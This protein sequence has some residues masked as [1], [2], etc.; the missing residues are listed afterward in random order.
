MFTLHYHPL[1]S[2]CHK[3]L[4]ALYERAVP[5]TGLVVD[6]QDAQSAAE[7]QKLWPVG[8]IPVLRDERNGRAVPETSIIIEYLDRAHPGA[9][10]LLPDDPDSQ[11][12]ARLWDR[13]FDLYVHTPMQKFVFDRLR[14]ENERD[15]R[16]V[17]DAR[18]A[19]L[20]AYD[21]LDERLAGKTWAVGD[22]FTIADCAAAPA[23]FYSHIVVPFDARHVRVAAY[24]E[25]LLERPSFRRVLDE[26]KPYFKFYPFNHAMPERFR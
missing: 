14:P 25:R 17:A 5:F 8:K 16:S 23:L 10:P 18:T 26:A 22:A 12:D 1:A 20:L 13:F 11:L 4:I 7:L 2:Y 3:V 9:P 19:L 6:L 15:P 24:F 21:M